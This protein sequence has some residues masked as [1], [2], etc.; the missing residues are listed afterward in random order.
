[1]SDCLFCKMV[2]GEMEPDIVYENDDVMAFRDINPAAPTHVLVI[3]RKH[4]PTVNDIGEDDRELVGKM[5]EAA[6]EVARREDI[7]DNGYRCVI[8]CGGD[9]QQSV[10][11]L[12]LHVMGGRKMNWPPG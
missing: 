9:A 7:A 12:H 5:Y 11:H 6:A 4:I 1:M 8:N 10:F 3:P 2:T